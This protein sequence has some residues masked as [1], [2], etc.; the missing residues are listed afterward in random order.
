MAEAISD[1][2]RRYRQTTAAVKASAIPKANFSA[3][4]KFNKRSV[5]VEEKDFHAVRL[6]ASHGISVRNA[7]R[8]EYRLFC[9][10]AILPVSSVIIPRTGIPF[11]STRITFAQ[12]LISG[13]Q[14]P[15]MTGHN[16]PISPFPAIG[17][18][19]TGLSRRCGNVIIQHAGRFIVDP[20]FDA[21]RKEGC[22]L[23]FPHP[24]QDPAVCFSLWMKAKFGFNRTVV[25]Q[26]IQP[27]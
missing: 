10:N 25:L 15:T 12:Q 1:H 18:C 5:S 26:P 6:H 14:T 16:L 23:L 4:P 24:N 27:N 9:R 20:D 11:N 17:F 13:F 8:N 22:R 2:C 21:V 3:P 19:I 7:L